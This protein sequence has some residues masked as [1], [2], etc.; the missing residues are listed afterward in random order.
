MSDTEITIS[1]LTKDIIKTIR[2]AKF[3]GD[4][5][6][7]YDFADDDGLAVSVM[8]NVLKGMGLNVFV[9]LSGGQCDV[10]T[11]RLYIDLTRPAKNKKPV[12]KKSKEK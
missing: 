4:S 2:A 10:D 8:S 1:D 11:K 7:S 12:N 3:A 9:V 5:F 6:V